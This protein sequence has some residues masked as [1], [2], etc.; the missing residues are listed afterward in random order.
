MT[1]G[2]A[3]IGWAKGG[4]VAYFES[5]TS[6]IRGLTQRRETSLEANLNLR[7][8]LRF[9]GRRWKLIAVV[10][11]ALTIAAVAV[12]TN[13]SSAFTS[14]AKLL[15]EQPSASPISTDSPASALTS[16]SSFIDSQVSVLTSSTL[17]ERVVRDAHLLDDPEFI[18]DEEPSLTDNIRARVADW[19][20]VFGTT[21]PI[22]HQPVTAL[23][24]LSSRAVSR[25]QDMIEV[26][27]EGR[28]YV[29]DIAVTSGD[30][31][32][33]ALIA[34]AVAEGYAE[35]QLQVRYHH[36]GRASKWLTERIAALQTQL[37]N[38][39][40]A[41]EEFKTKNNLVST[42]A[43]TLT[44][45]QLSELNLQLIGS[46]TE[47]AEKRAQFEQAQKLLASGGD[48]E[49]IPQVLG[50]EV[51][52]A[53]RTQ[54]AEV[55]RREADLVS[56]Y[57]ARHPEV[58]K[59]QAERRDVEFQISSEVK[60]IVGNL[61]NELEV[62]ETR[63]AAL[64]YSL[65][66]ATGQ[67]A[68]DNQ[69][70]IQV[71]ELERIANA[72]KALY[73]AFLSRAKMADEEK[74]FSDSGVRIISVASVSETPS[75]PPK[76]VIILFGLIVGLGLGTGGALAREL[77]NAGFAT[78]GQAEKDLGLP[79]L[80][81]VPKLSEPKMPAIRGQHSTQPALFRLEPRSGY[82]EAIRSLR[83]ALLD[84]VDQGR[85]PVI[86]ITS[87][88]A[89]EGKTTTAINLAISAASAGYRV[90]IV[91]ADLRRSG[92]TKHFCMSDLP[93]LVDLVTDLRHL[94]SMV[95]FDDA[96]ATYV[97]P[98]GK[99]T[100]N[101]SDLLG[102]SRMARFL[103]S[104]RRSFDLVIVDSPPICLMADAPVLAKHADLVALVVKW[105][106]TPREAVADALRR[107]NGTKVAG[108]AMTM[109]NEKQAAGYG[110]SYGPYVAM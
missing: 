80:A 66:Q 79:I 90:L 47:L 3:G 64:A 105:N 71:R 86:Q 53:L 56:H 103:G 23:P 76:K 77:L 43:G 7:E 50:S 89:G 48:L 45:Q 65:G 88:V 36:A 75:Y 82:S 9:Y 39:E 51:I 24:D 19:L 20:K 60:R 84:D 21:E 98:A 29:I 18:S 27:R 99:G 22:E 95:R 81:S 46:R 40:D 31:E 26:W 1:D 102:S 11:A 55:T 67:T 74:T 32:K 41:V 109:I 63:E 37:K 57:G 28:S 78:T 72:N 17:L 10:A 73:E 68:A 106:S 38:A 94:P 85:A 62:A 16:D 54:H 14:T 104:A 52:K 92:L 69:I 97:L 33:A 101:P 108:I 83:H 42:R 70:A 91:D 6:A 96:T 61:A 35:D 5:S 30:P 100:L 8:V 58:S 34:N 87:A 2:F 25:L 93:G 4:K 44:E 12:A 107:L 110:D 13:I 59:V 49:S 15:L